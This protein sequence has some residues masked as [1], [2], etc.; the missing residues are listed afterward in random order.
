[1]AGGEKIKGDEGPY[2]PPPLP[3]ARDVKVRQRIVTVKA[4]AM[5]VTSRLADL[6]PGERRGERS[7]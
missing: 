1:M 5:G 4:T 6:K 2:S 7:A 3:T